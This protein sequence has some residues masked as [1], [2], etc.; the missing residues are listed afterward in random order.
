[1]DDERAALRKKL[2]RKVELGRWADE[3]WNTLPLA[4]AIEAIE[5]RIR[6]AD[7]DDRYT[8]TLELSTCCFWRDASLRPNVSSMR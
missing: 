7:S 6:G 4:E 2:N 5:E 1:M 8:L 3:L